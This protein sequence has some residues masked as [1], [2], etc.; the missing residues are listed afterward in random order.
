MS[1]TV[2]KSF[3]PKKNDREIFILS[4]VIL[5][6]ILCRLLTFPY[7]TALVMAVFTF[8]ISF[9]FYSFVN[10]IA[11]SENKSH[12]TQEFSWG[13]VREKTENLNLQNLFKYLSTKDLDF[14]KKY[15]FS[16]SNF[17][18]LFL[19]IF[20]DFIIAFKNLSFFDT[21]IYFAMSI[22]TKFTFLGYIIMNDM[23]NKLKDKSEENILDVFYTQMNGLLS[24]FFVI[25]ILFFV[26]SKYIVEIFFG[27]NFSPYQSSL[28]FIL[29]ANISL[30]ISLCV[31]TTA[32]KINP[33][34]TG[35]ITQTFILIFTLLFIFMPINYIDTITYFVVGSS[36]ILSIF[37]YNFVIKKHDY[38][39]N[40]YNLSF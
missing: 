39:E 3:Q 1:S 24:V 21:G 35:R 4:V 22:F 18:I 8:L 36:T 32:Q 37:L 29:V 26:L 17:I 25:F 5:F 2:L 40:T 10:K 33:K 19:F 11:K 9:N 15:L 13:F 28:P 12:N 16:N 20:T 30:C 14:Y 23:F 34:L 31:Y 7:I 27:N 38:I 6:S